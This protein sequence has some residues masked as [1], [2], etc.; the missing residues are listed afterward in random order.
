MA[1]RPT[2]R[3]L[4]HLAESYLSEY[5]SPF[6]GYAWP[7][8]DIDDSPESLVPTDT[9]APALLS[10]PINGK[11][12]RQLFAQPRD[13][14]VA[15]PYH[16]LLCALEAVVEDGEAGRRNFESLEADELTVRSAPG[17]GTVL[18]AID[19]V[20][21]CPGLTSVAVTKVLHRKRP[22][23]VPINDSRV[24]SFYEIKGRSY[25]PLFEAIHRDLQDNAQLLDRW[26]DSVD[27]RIKMTRLRCL[28]IVVWMHDA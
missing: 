16:G 27:T 26:V 17:W 4:A 10:Y 1:C 11:Y 24:R 21:P 9:L 6:S 14:D 15:N 7:A 20:Q 8:Y 18:K 2:V 28:D 19:A 23:L 25:A 5:C 12:L 13:N 3:S 22:A